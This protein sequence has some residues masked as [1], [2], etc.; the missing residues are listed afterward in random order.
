MELSISMFGDNHFDAEGKAQPTN[1]RLLELIEEIKLMD[2]LGIDFFGIGE[3]HRPG[4]VSVPE[5]VLAAASTVTSTIKLGSAVTVLSSRWS[6]QGLPVI[7]HDRPDQPGDVPRS[8][9]AGQFHRSF[10]C[11]VTTWRLWCPVWRKNRPAG[12]RSMT[13][14]PLPGKEHSVRR[15]INNQYYRERSMTIW[16]F[17]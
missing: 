12:S 1:R 14:I 7:C 10:P 17:G 3:H 15:W 13:M 2:E 16:I 8:S 6:R 11:M 9:P 5:I 4:V